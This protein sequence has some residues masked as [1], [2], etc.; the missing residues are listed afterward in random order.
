ME[1]NLLRVFIMPEAH[2]L[3]RPLFKA[4]PVRVVL[5][6]SKLL[7]P[8]ALIGIAYPLHTKLFGLRPKIHTG[9]LY[10]AELHWFGVSSSAGTETLNEWLFH[11]TSPLLDLIC[12]GSYV[13]YLVPTVALFVYLALHDMPTARVYAWSLL[14][15]HLLAFATY[16]VFPAAPPWYIQMHG[17]GPAVLSAAPSA[18]GVARF[19]QLIGVPIGH[20]FYAN[21]KNVF[22]AVPSLHVGLQS[23]G[24]LVAW[25]LHRRWAYG[26][27]GFTVVIFFSALYLGHHYTIDLVSG[28]LAS[29][30]A[31]ATVRGTAHACR[32]RLTRKVSVKP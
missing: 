6:W 28:L 12:G 27:V 13:A 5:Q 2:L 8:I 20:M 7:A 18:A 14:T 3:Q 21:N 30:V 16:I 32:A 24:A 11:H 9:D 1:R 22:G 29:A 26:M 23:L 25:P 17:S 31:I 19:D 10:Q 4:W 15:L